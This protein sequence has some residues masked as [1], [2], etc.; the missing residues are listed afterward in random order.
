[1]SKVVC[2]GECLVDMMPSKSGYVPNA[3]VRLATFARA[4]LVLA[5]M[6]RILA[7]SAVT[8]MPTFCMIKSNPQG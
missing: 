5:R 4:W 3:G 1:M 8:A 6:R 7:N 2:I